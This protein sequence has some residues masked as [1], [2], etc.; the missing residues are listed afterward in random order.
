[1]HP[2]V[3][4]ARVRHAPHSIVQFHAFHD[5]DSTATDQSRTERRQPNVD[6]QQRPLAMP[7]R[8]S[9]VKYEK[10]AG[11]AE[12]EAVRGQKQQN[13]KGWTGGYGTRRLKS[14]QP[15]ASRCS[16]FPHR[17]AGNHSGLI[18]EEI[19][20]KASPRT[21]A[22]HSASGEGILCRYSSGIIAAPS[23]SSLNQVRT[24][25]TKPRA[26]GDRAARFLVIR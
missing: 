13:A 8:K 2:T 26:A 4:L 19:P 5:S 15:P 7:R 18:D 25:S 12:A 1:M 21:V 24:C 20:Q 17:R 22:R 11:N 9:V 16:A 14:P 6:G 23:H 3:A 10:R